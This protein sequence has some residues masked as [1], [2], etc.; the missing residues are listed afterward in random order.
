[1]TAFPLPLSTSLEVP[2][3]KE[4]LFDGIVM[5]KSRT[6]T[7]VLLFRIFD[8]ISGYIWLCVFGSLLV[9]SIIFFVIKFFDDRQTRAMGIFPE[10][11]DVSMFMR[12][13]NVIFQS[14]SAVLL[15][16]VAN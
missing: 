3:S 2:H 15:A 13:I 8:C 5:V 11:Q 4:I 12:F 6:E 1:M 14:I 9:V 10:D 16:K 7:K